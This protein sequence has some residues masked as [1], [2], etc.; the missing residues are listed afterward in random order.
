MQYF[1]HILRYDGV[2]LMLN[3]SFSERF[4]KKYWK[5]LLQGIKN[6]LVSFG[7]QAWNSLYL[8]RKSAD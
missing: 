3:W 6:Y 5:A 7:K 2:V 1:Y 8:P 4:I